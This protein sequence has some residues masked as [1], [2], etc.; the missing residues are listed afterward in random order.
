MVVSVNP[1][2]STVVRKLKVS[3]D[4]KLLAI[5][6]DD[7]MIEVV[8]LDTFEVIQT[9]QAHN[10]RISDIDFTQQSDFTHGWARWVSAILRC[11]ERRKRQ[12]QS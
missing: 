9:I 3:A 5:G 4:G 8:S 11:K 1:G 12:G 10:G 6:G 2:Q 7:E